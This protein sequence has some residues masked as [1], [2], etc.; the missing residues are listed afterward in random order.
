MRTQIFK[1]EKSGAAIFNVDGVIYF[2]DAGAS[3]N[4]FDLNNEADFR[5]FIKDVII[6]GGYTDGLVQTIREDGIGGCSF[7]DAVAFF[8]ETIKPLI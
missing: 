7:E 4:S 1:N 8:N 5:E 6:G 2:K 3:L